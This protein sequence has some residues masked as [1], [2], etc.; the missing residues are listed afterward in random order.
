MLNI[1][2]NLNDPEI[3]LALATDEPL[4]LP[5]EWQVLW[6][7]LGGEGTRPSPVAGNSLVRVFNVGGKLALLWG[8]KPLPLV[9][10]ERLAISYVN[11][12]TNGY[13]CPHVSLIFTPPGETV[14]EAEEVVVNHFPVATVFDAG[15]SELFLSLAP[16]RLKDAIKHVREPFILEGL[17]YADDHFPG[18]DDLSV[19][20]VGSFTSESKFGTGTYSVAKVRAGGKDYKVRVDQQ[21]NA[22]LP[23]LVVSPTAPIPGVVRRK[24]KYLKLVALKFTRAQVK[25]K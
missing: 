7:L 12:V 23:R 10:G 9:A 6:E 24:G 3:A 4:E 21:V 25:A 20:L 8:K 5:P 16:S 15:S 11:Y 19:E 14:A 2:L 18:Q 17:E 13:S 1:T 22:Y